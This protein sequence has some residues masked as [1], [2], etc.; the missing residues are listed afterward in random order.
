M[1][2]L[3]AGRRRYIFNFKTENK[4]KRQQ[5]AFVS[6]QSFLMTI[7]TFIFRQTASII[8]VERTH[9]IFQSSQTRSH[10]LMKKDTR[11]T[12]TGNITELSCDED[13]KVKRH[14]EQSSEY[15][16]QGR[17]TPLKH[18]RHH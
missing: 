8:Q 16:V 13:N 9:Q 14:Y 2:A 7:P 11:R 18:I 4:R 15:C 12:F 10:I 3:S 6:R 1:G 17:I 5:T